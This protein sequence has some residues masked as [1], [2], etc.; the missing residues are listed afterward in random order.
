MGAQAR[1]DFQKDRHGTPAAFLDGQPL[2]PEVLFD[3]QTLGE[4]VRR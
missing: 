3:P 1:Q 4:L 2:A